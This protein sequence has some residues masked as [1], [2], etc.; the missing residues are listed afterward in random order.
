MAVRTTSE[1]VHFSDDIGGQVSRIDAL[2]PL[3]LTVPPLMATLAG[4][5]RWTLSKPSRMS[6][7][8]RSATTESS[9]SPP[10]A[11]SALPS[12]TLT[13]SSPSSPETTSRPPPGLIVS[14][15]DPPEK[16][17]DEAPPVSVSLP[18]PPEPVTAKRPT[19]PTV[20][21]SSPPRPLACIVSL[22]PMSSVNGTRFVRSNLMRAPFG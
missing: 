1:P 6:T 19:S 9:P 15:P 11:A 13:L 16:C 10:R 20:I 14:L 5:A 3:T 22:E 12:R 8:L 7:P 17:S 4:F 18:E 21:E 2:A